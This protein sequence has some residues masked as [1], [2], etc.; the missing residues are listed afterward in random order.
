MRKFLLGFLA[1]VSLA[2]LLSGC[3]YY[4]Y[5][6]PDDYYGRGHRYDRGDHGE[7]DRDDRHY[8]RRYYR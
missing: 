4:P 5:P 1:V 6:Y 3:F 2:S 8:D 7:R